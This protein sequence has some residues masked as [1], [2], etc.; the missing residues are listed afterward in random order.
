MLASHGGAAGAAHPRAL[1]AP[2]SCGS[3]AA[4]PGNAER[5]LR[6]LCLMSDLWTR[7]SFETHLAQLNS[8]SKPPASI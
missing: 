7:G 3:Y 2:R 8:I 4:Q 1:Q 6:Q 5:R